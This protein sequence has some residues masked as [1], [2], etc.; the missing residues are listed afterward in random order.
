MNW[1]FDLSFA[2]EYALSPQR[3][4]S[5]AGVDRPSD[6]Q[7]RHLRELPMFA[8][9]RD[10][11]TR[12]YLVATLRDSI[13]KRER[14]WFMPMTQPVWEE[15]SAYLPDGVLEPL[16]GVHE[17]AGEQV[18]PVGI[19]PIK[20]VE[21][22]VDRGGRADLEFLTQALRDVDGLLISPRVYKKLLAAGVPIM[23][24]ML[25]TRY[26]TNPRVI[27]YAVV[28]IYSALRALP[29]M[30][31]PQ[32]H[33]SVAVLWAIDLGTAIPYTWGVLAM[34]TA[35]RFRMRLLGMVVTVAT[36]MAPYIYFGFYGEHYPP[37]IWGIIAL[38]I[39][40]TFVLEGYKWWGDR[41]ISRALV[42]TVGPAAPGA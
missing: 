22:L 6:L 32:F 5:A 17:V 13:R 34:V 4:V 40:G 19:A 14:L 29:V 10:T 30:F 3:V 37:W 27:A 21:A 41:R 9:L 20:L 1:L 35:P 33:G 39:A 23:K 16:G 26:A 2:E 36:F 25:L 42:R 24:R 18:V 11:Q 28:I 8:G 38:L 31:V 7:D 12:R 15:W